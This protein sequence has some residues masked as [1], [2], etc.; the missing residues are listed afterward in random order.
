MSHLMEIRNQFLSRT[1]SIL[2][3][4]AVMAIA[5]GAWHFLDRPGIDGQVPFVSSQ[6][7]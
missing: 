3:V 4:V 5:F 1:T 6:D 2:A 7:R